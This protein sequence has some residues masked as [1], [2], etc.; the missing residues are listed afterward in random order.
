[1]E[2]AL[3]WLSALFAGLAAIVTYLMWRSTN[4]TRNEEQAEWKGR[5]DT[6]LERIMDELKEVRLRLNGLDKRLNGLGERLNG[7]GERL[8]GLGERL[9]GLDGRLNGL[10]GRLDRVEGGLDKVEGR[11]D[12]VERKIETNSTAINQL[13]QIVFTR[14]NIPSVTSESPLRLSELGKTLSE[15][16]DAEAWVER[17]ADQLKVN[18]AGKD[19]YEIQ[20]FCFDYVENTDQ[21]SDQE[22]RIIHKVAYQR[23]I[24]AEEIRRVLAIELRD[25]L[26]EHTGLA[27]RG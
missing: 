7:L 21:Y 18:V 24:M 27:S 4:R 19:A 9:N 20:S 26:L 8:N 23:G 1:M 2:I 11:L 25:K 5:I 12:C 6:V 15:E 14:F 10:D 22:R 17:I 3:A 13:R 16:I